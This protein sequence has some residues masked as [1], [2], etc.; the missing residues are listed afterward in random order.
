MAIWYIL[1]KHKLKLY[2]SP[3]SACQQNAYYI[4]KNKK[5]GGR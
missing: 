4:S 3:S 5:I 1:K 2:F